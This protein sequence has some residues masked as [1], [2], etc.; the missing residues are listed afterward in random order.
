MIL[1]HGSDVEVKTPL[2]IKSEKG[3]DFGFAFYLTPIKKQAERMARRKQRIN[4][5][6]KAI[7]SVYEWNEDKETIIYKNFPSPDEEW[8][9]FIIN[10][11]TDINIHHGYDVVEGRIADDSVGETI[12]F[13]IEGVMKKEDAIERL[14]FQ[15]INTQIAF[16]S[17]PALQSLK[18]ISSFEVGP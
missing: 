16:C 6:D 8:L 7:V 9:D 18:Y 17:E 4:R 13:V 3:R 5:S 12:L 1:Y 11:R 2:I 14:K 15:K 10:C